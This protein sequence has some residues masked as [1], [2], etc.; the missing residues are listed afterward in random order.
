MKLLFKLGHQPHISA[1]EIEAILGIAPNVVEGHAIVETDANPA[2]LMDRL[3]GTVYVGEHIGSGNRL[4]VIAD[5]LEQHEGK[6]HFSTSGDKRLAL[7]IKKELKNRGRSV[8]YIEMKNTA[9]IIHNNLVQ[10]QGHFTLH[11][12]DVFV[13][14]AVQQIDDFSDRDFGRPGRD[15]KSGML[16][17][18]LAR[19]MINLSGAKTDQTLLDPFC[20]SGTVLTEALLMGFDNIIGSD[21]SEKAIA[22]SKTNIAWTRENSELGIKNYELLQTDARELDDKLEKTNIDAIVTEPY[23]GKPLSGK[24]RRSELEGQAYELG[25]LYTNAF[26]AFHKILKPNGIALFIIPKFHNQDTWVEIDCVGKI[27]KLGFDVVGEPLLYWRTN[28]HVGR[29]IYKFKKINSLPL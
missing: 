5:F 9:T 10:K 12:K 25:K 18:K 6:I 16:P 24:E 22:D 8:R 7:D 21:L 26:K 20:G 28:Q 4:K 1:A 17:P 27:K 23:L 15:N 29:T 2:E 11:G 3:G 13:T 19:I 14:R